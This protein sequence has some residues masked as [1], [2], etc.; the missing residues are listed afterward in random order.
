[1]GGRLALSRG[2]QPPGP[3]ERRAPDAPKK[4]AQLRCPDYDELKTGLLARFDK[5]RA[6]LDELCFGK[7]KNPGQT[8][9]INLVH[10]EVR[11][12]PRGEGRVESQQKM[13]G[14]G[15]LRPDDVR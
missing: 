5:V 15:R 3:P 11:I 14:I 2:T 7:D 12:V 4:D 13:V 9:G 10:D 1:M 6:A 8:L